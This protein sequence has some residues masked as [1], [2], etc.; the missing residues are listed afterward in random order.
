MRIGVIGRERGG[1]MF[2]GL[3]D[4]VYEWVM[5]LLAA[6]RTISKR[7]EWDIFRRANRR[8]P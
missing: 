2:R 3:R 4:I 1:D 7:S 5:I 6:A 8:C